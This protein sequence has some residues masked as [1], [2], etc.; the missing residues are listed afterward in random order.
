LGVRTHS[1]S[2]A[3][4]III[5]TCLPVFG[6]YT[7]ALSPQNA[8]LAAVASESNDESIVLSEGANPGTES[9]SVH[10][11]VSALDDGTHEV[12][13]RNNLVRTTSGLREQPVS[14]AFKE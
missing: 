5:G 7:V 4:A 6:E 10:S 14:Q 2:K 3:S 1:S 8:F 12:Q 13:L 9:S 11:R